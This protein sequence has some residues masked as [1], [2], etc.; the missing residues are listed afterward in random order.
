MGRSC[1]MKSSRRSGWTNRSGN[2]RS[3]PVIQA[4]YGVPQALTWNM[5]TVT[6]SRSDSRSSKFTQIECEWSQMDRWL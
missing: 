1:A 3:V 4:A 6:K 5:G 2:S